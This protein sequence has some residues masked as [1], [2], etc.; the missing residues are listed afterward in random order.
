MNIKTRLLTLIVVLLLLSAAC[1][2]MT[3][4]VSPDGDDANSG[5]TIDAPLKTIH[6]ALKRVGSGDEIR[7]LPG[8]YPARTLLYKIHGQPEKPLVIVSHS[9]DP[10]QFAVIDGGIQPSGT[11][12]NVHAFDI[13]SSSWIVFQN[14]VIRNCW[15][16]VTEIKD[17]Q[18]LTFRGCRFTGGRRVIVPNGSTS[19]HILVENCFWE[20][21]P[22]VWTTFDWL[23]MHH[24]SMGYYNG[25][26][27]HPWT[28]GGSIVMR[29]NTIINVYN[30]Y[31]HR[32]AA[33]NQDGNSEIY[34]NTISNVAD[35]DFEPESWAWNLHY[36]HNRL[37][38]VHKLY[39]ID[40]VQ[41]GPIYIY[42]NT[43]TQDT[44]S[45]AVNRISG[46]WKFKKGPLQEPCYA[47][48][49]S[50]YTEAKAFKKDE[51][52][53]RQ[54]K[55]F[56]NAYFFFA[57]SGGFALP[58]WDDSFRFDYDASNMPWPPNI[59]IHGQERHGIITDIMF[60]N[61]PGRDLRLRADSPCIDAGTVMTFPELGWTQEFEGSAPD[62]GAWEED[63]LV[64]GPPFRFREPPGGVSY[65]EKP[66]I[67]R[68][69]VTGK[70]LTLF[71]SAP[72]NPATISAAIV[73][74]WQDS[75][76]ADVSAVTV[77][78]EHYRVEIQ[79]AKPL[80]AEKLHISFEPM[81]VGENGET[82]TMWASTIGYR[83]HSFETG[84]KI[85]VDKIK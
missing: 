31:R 14:L 39:S 60:K 45:I 34:D 79:A 21:D 32:S 15:T 12:Q 74:V 16:D 35:N 54:L 65:K 84:N 77:A 67:V 75:S 59:T 51:A 53:N 83:A 27:V 11:S 56:N 50:Y 30:A 5:H 24:L 57:D 8:T 1:W 3:L 69:R 66:R 33:W 62:I 19:H 78:P 58:D 40:E 23:Q 52:T 85:N 76:E 41:G 20:Q 22:R 70:T 43:F 64:E 44:D 10:S 42:G 48:N 61:G 38:N 25:A 29:G 49:N 81:P 68:H 6:E 71:F 13:R 37:H 73:H 63:H 28:S 2:S 36:Y 17:S 82:A 26:L 80:L 9:P 4:F 7:L 18:Y 72:L 46:M 47:F 55:H